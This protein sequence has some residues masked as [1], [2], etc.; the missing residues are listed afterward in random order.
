VK[1][2]H[3]FRSPFLE[4]IVPKEESQ[5]ALVLHPKNFI[6]KKAEPVSPNKKWLTY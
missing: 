1:L 5:P 3:E 2:H 4:K 6:I